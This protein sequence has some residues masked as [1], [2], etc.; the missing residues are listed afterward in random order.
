VILPIGDTPNPRFTPWL[1]W[2]MIAI[3]IGVFL[4]LW[5]K[6]SQPVDPGDPRLLD[7][8]HTL[9]REQG[10]SLAALRELARG[11][12]VYDLIVLE[13]GFRPAMPSLHD[14]LTSMFLHG[15]FSHLAGNMLF[16]WIFGDNVE[17]RLGRIGY[18]AFYVLGGL[19]ACAGDALLRMGSTV[20]SVGAS[21]AI[22][23][24][25][26]AY[27]VWFP[28]NQVRLY[29]LFFP[30]FMDVVQ[31]PARVVL[32]VYV[33]LQNLL[34]AF[35]QW[36]ASEGAATGGGVSYGAHLGGFAAGAAFAVWLQSSGLLQRGAGLLVEPEN[37]ASRMLA[38]REA[39]GDG[40]HVRAARLW[41]AGRPDDPIGALDAGEAL[42][43]TQALER[44]G[45]EGLALAVA[46]RAVRLHGRS[47]D[48]AAL[49]LSACRLLLA[50][51]RITEAW[52]HFERAAALGVPPAMMA[53]AHRLHGILLSR[54][55]RSPDVFFG[56]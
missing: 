21:G 3:N 28:R 44:R 24:V 38:V 5:P 15:G 52:P 20:P 22:S 41:L 48:A 43:L 37:P 25:L 42:A 54:S 6:M 46:V 12:S 51:G 33:L 18:L 11:L 35:V 39:L 9:A 47:R 45:H 50:A 16:L 14:A 2:A 17:H 1:N 10:H 55:R 27:F 23:A 8:L 4:V 49:H 30:F 31:V 19:G 26:G 40:A 34:P 56:P 13:H 32:A 53:E 29:V 36:L 7:Y